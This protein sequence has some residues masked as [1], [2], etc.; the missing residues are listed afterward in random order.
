[1]TDLTDDQKQHQHFLA[2]MVKGRRGDWIATASGVPFFPLDP[3]PEEVRLE[4][5]VH[6]LSQ[7]CR[8]SGHTSVPYSV[9]EHSIHVAKLIEQWGGTEAEI[10]TGLTH[11]GSE[12]YMIDLPRPVKNDIMMAPYVAAECRVQAVIAE[13]LHLPYPFPEIVKQADTEILGYEAEGLMPTNG[14]LKHYYIL[15]EMKD[16][17]W[18]A[19][20]LSPD[21]VREEFW[22]MWY[23]HREARRYL[24]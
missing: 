10:L 11:D 18:Y 15:P 21:K 24:P 2:Q 20:E 3:R 6:A 17:N 9:L 5:I 19:L 13:H 22:D 12:T 23:W 1:M 7:Q 14:L 4:D 8:W 16:Y